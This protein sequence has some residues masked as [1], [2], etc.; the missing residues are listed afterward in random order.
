M[1][2]QFGV[3]AAGCFGASVALVRDRGYAPACVVFLLSVGFGLLTY[4]E[5][6]LHF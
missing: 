1:A 5:L 2:I 6:G 4:R 3:L